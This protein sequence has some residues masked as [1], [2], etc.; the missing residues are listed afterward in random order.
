[1]DRL[2]KWVLTGQ[3]ATFEVRETNR[4]F[5]G[6]EM[7]LRNWVLEELQER[8][9]PLSLKYVPNSEDVQ[10]RRLKN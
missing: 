9:D 6:C 10:N 7:E 1:M 5:G 8:T 2:G 3:R 4:Y